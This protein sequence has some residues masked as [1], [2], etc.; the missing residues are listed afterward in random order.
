MERVSAVV[1]YPTPLRRAD[2]TIIGGINL[3]VDMSDRKRRGPA[4]QRAA[5]YNSCTAC[6]DWPGSRTGR[7]R[8]VYAN[9]AAER[10]FATGLGDLLSGR[11][12]QEIFR[13]RHCR[14]VHGERS[15]SA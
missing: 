14:R 2:G 5:V 4:R 15:A 1:P 8:Y 11:T 10:A 13:A 7:A 12:D 3:L 6:R 9:E